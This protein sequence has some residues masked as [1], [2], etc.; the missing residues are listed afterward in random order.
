MC[1]F[2]TTCTSIRF[3]TEKIS[4]VDDRKG[5]KEHEFS[6]AGREKTDTEEGVINDVCFWMFCTPAFI[7]GSHQKLRVAEL[8]SRF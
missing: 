8:F 3:F 5:A 4:R 7:F 1:L 2:I 6:V